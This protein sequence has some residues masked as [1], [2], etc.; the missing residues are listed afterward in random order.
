MRLRTILDQD[1]EAFLDEQCGIEDDESEADREN[2]VASTSF[3]ECAYKMLMR[4]DGGQ[5]EAS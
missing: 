1:V 2:V 4:G 5:R 3:E